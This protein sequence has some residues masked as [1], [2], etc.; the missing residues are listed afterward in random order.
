MYA[1]ENRLGKKSY[2]LIG[3][4][5][6]AVLMYDTFRGINS[7][8]Y[9]SIFVILFAVSIFQLAKLHKWKS[10]LADKLGPYYFGIYLVHS[11]F[12]NVAYKMMHINIAEYGLPWITIVLFAIVIFALSLVLTYVLQLIPAFKKYVL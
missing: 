9:Y 7:V 11:F 1:G 2:A 10:T 12:L 6:V 5:S 3:V 4:V 8:P